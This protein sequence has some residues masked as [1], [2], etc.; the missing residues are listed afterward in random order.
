MIWGQYWAHTCPA[1]IVHF[2]TLTFNAQ[3][4]ILLL[5][6]AFWRG[7]L[8]LNSNTKLMKK[9]IP[10]AR[11]PFAWFRREPQHSLSC[12]HASVRASRVRAC[13]GTSSFGLALYSI[14]SGLSYAAPTASRTAWHTLPRCPHRPSQPGTPCLCWTLETALCKLFFR[15][16]PLETDL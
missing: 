9:W 4:L 10:Q 2:N 12:E 3:P 14:L 1:T 8:L 7:C 16:C 5:E 15:G 6:E 13:G 11:C